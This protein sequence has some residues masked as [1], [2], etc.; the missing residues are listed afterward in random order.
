MVRPT[1]PGFS[2]APMTATVDGVKTAT[3]VW[4]GASYTLAEDGEIPNSPWKVLQ[5]NSNSVVMLFGDTQVTLSTGEGL[6]K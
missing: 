4:N 6:T 3:F 2:V 1:L 5:I